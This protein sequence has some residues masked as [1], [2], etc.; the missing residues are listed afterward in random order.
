VKGQYEYTD[1]TSGP[2]LLHLTGQHTPQSLMVEMFPKGSKIP[3]VVGEFGIGTS[4]LG[5]VYPVAIKINVVPGVT[6]VSEP[7]NPMSTGGIDSRAQ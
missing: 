1:K 6:A 5:L 4:P 3:V 7:D 2:I